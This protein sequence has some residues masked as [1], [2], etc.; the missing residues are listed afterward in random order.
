MLMS[1]PCLYVHNAGWWDGDNNMVQRV[2][3]AKCSKISCLSDWELLCL[4]K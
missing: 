1:D 4:T 2:G 3:D